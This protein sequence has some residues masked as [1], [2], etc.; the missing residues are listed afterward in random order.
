MPVLLHRHMTRY[1]LVFPTVTK[2]FCYTLVTLIDGAWVFDTLSALSRL[3]VAF[4]IPKQ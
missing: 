3:E 2:A 1:P 4:E